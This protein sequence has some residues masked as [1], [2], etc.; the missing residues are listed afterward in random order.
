MSRLGRP[1]LSG[2]WG[3]ACLWGDT[4]E[5]TAVVDVWPWLVGFHMYIEHPGLTWARASPLDLWLAA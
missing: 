3:A 2:S 4:D 5:D 1:L